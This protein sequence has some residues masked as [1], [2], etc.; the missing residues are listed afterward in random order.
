MSPTGYVSQ[1]TSENM[2]GPVGLAALPSPLRA[3]LSALATGRNEP[4][5]QTVW[6]ICQWFVEEEDERAE[7]T[8]LEAVTFWI[9][10]YVF[11]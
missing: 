1:A 10:N 11:A 6:D 3:S 7:G 9:D 5:E 8:V 4:I 2:I